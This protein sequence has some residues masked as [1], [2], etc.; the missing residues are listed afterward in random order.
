MNVYRCTENRQSDARP[1]V[2]DMTVHGC[3][4]SMSKQSE[5]KP[6]LACAA[7]YSKRYAAN[8]SITPPPLDSDTDSDGEGAAAFPGVPEPLSVFLSALPWSSRSTVWHWLY[9]AKSVI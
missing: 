9:S 7:A 3:T 8:S 1:E 6:G 4:T 5:T 2:E